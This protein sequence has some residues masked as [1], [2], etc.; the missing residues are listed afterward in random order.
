MQKMT[1]I[2]LLKAIRIDDQNL[3]VIIVTGHPGRENL[4]EAERYGVTAF[5]TKPLDVAGFMSTL[6]RLDMHGRPAASTENG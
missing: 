2:E 4:V 6:S 3:P 1:V 5:F